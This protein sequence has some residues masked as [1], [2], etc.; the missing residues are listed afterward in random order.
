MSI[1]GL[2]ILS[3]S[4]L[5]SI[6]AGKV[7]LLP[8]AGIF[9]IATAVVDVVSLVNRFITKFLAIRNMEAV[10]NGM[11]QGQAPQG[12]RDEIWR[13]AQGAWRKAQGERTDKGDSD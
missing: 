10:F 3:A 11:A 7:E 8:A 12:L 13:G 2:F 5:A 1:V 4:L 6:W 9:F